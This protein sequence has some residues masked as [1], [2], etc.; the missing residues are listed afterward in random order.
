[1]SRTAFLGSEGVALFHL[2]FEARP[3]DTVRRELFRQQPEHSRAGWFAPE[4]TTVK[5]ATLSKGRQSP[6]G[7]LPPAKKRRGGKRKS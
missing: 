1:M 3:G 5:V 7:K 4:A 2:P 6:V